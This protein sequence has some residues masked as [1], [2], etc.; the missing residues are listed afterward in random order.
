MS[1]SKFAKTN[2]STFSISKRKNKVIQS[3]L[4]NENNNNH[5]INVHRID[6]NNIGDFYCAPHLYFDELKGGKLDIFEFKSKDEKIANNWIDKIS[7]NALIIGG[8]GLLNRSCFKMQLGVFEQLAIKGKKTVLWGIGHNSK[9][10][11]EFGKIS[12]YNINTKNFGLVGVRDYEINENWV[13]C[14]SC[15]HSIFDKNFYETQDIGIIFH[16]KTIKNKALLKKLK[17]YPSTSNTTNLEDIIAFI[18][19]SKTIVTDSYHAMYWSIL[20]EKKVVAIPNSSKFFNFKYN[21][22]I[23]S[24]DNFDKDVSKAQSYSGVLEECREVN[25]KFADKVFDYLN[26]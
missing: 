3:I 21:P 9:S 18:G 25:L 15:I 23:S 19:A 12:S 6:T 10:K 14:V 4:N 7:N 22:V 1:I 17:S 20:L 8:G 24:F 16:K 2:L 26:L 5:V 11:N 13:P